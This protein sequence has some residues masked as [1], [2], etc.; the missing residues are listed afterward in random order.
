MELDTRQSNQW[1]CTEQEQ[2][3]SRGHPVSFQESGMLEKRKTGFFPIFIFLSA[4]QFL[5][6]IHI[7]AMMLSVLMGQVKKA[8]ARGQS[9]RDYLMVRFAA[10]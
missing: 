3:I 4:M 5:L 1:G 7:S 2:Q 6:I 10:S 9:E 8:C